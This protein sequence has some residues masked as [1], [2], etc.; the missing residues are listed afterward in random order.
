ML[1][2]LKGALKRTD[3]HPHGE[4]DPR[5]HVQLHHEVDVDEDAEQRQ[6]GQQRDLRARSESVASDSAPPNDL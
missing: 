6:P 3:D 4:V 5:L 1:S 2:K